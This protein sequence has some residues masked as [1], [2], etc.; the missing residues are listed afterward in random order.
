MDQLGT[1]REMIDFISS[2]HLPVNPGMQFLTAVNALAYQSVSG[3]NLQH[4][5]FKLNRNN[6]VLK[7]VGLKEI[8]FNARLANFESCF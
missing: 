7:M 5:I 8:R 4:A 1:A 2:D 3:K 6:A